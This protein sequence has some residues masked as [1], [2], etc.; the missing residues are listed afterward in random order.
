MKFTQFSDDTNQNFFLSQPHQP[1]FVLAFVNAVVTMFIFLLSY[2]GLLH[3]SIPVV[4]FHAYAL[5]YLFFT[6]ALFAFL[7]SS[8]PDFTSAPA[9]EK[10][11]YMQVFNLYYLG[12]VLFL[13]GSIVSQFLSVIGTFILFSAHVKGMW[14]LKT[15]YEN[16]SLEEEDDIL[17]I[18]YSLYAGVFAHLLYILSSL[19]YPSLMHFSMEVAIY[20]YLFLL[21]FTVAQRMVPIFSEIETEKRPKLLQQIFLLLIVHTLL[22][23]LYTNSTFAVDIYLAYFIT[24]ELKLWKLSFSNT[25]PLLWIFHLSL[26]WIP[27][28]F[29]VTGLTHFCT[30]FFDIP[31]LSLD[32]HLITLGFIFSML[33][34]FVTS[35]TLGHSG[36]DI[37]ADRWVRLLFVWT[38]VVVFIRILVSLFTALGTDIQLLFDISVAVWIILFIVWGIRFFPVLIYGKKLS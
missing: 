8:F 17:W 15:M 16:H 32:I 36:S 30:L 23:E 28:A 3:F 37:Q 31:F 10:K 9:I 22:E 4:H 33:V 1:F 35:V 38:Q 20:L 12:A 13:L 2:K 7:F 18:L 24:K 25:D 26:F 19:F 34:G 5:I 29:A 14:I 21:T 27:L 11:R 6:P